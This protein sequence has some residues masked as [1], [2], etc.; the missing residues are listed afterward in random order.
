MAMAIVVIVA[1]RCVLLVITSVADDDTLSGGT[2]YFDTGGAHNVSVSSPAARERVIGN[3]LRDGRTFGP[4][5]KHRSIMYR[6]VDRGYTHINN[7][8]DDNDDEDGPDVRIS[9][10]LHDP[11]TLPLTNVFNPYVLCPTGEV[12]IGKSRR[13]TGQYRTGVL[14]PSLV[15]VAEDDIGVVEEGANSGGRVLDFTA[16]LSTNLRVMFVGDSVLVQLAHAVDESLLEGETIESRKIGSRS[17]LWESWTGHDGGSILAPT[18]GGGVS[19]TWRMT[20]LISMANEGNPPANSVGGGMESR[21]NRQ[22][23]EL[24]VSSVIDEFIAAGRYVIAGRWQQLD[25]RGRG[26]RRCR[27]PRHAR[28]DGT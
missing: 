15:R 22:V 13:P 18:R 19:A 20:G 24:Q 16:T 6:R 7:V 14:P 5:R 12:M 26:L 3:D 17:V 10:E 1:F 4:T 8:D 28:L 23:S 27:I 25:D 11:R 9:F 2:G 21:G